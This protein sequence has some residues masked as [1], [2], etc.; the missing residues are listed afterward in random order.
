MY[1]T[2]KQF[3]REMHLHFDEYSTFLRGLTRRKIKGLNSK[4]RKLHK[5]AFKVIDCGACANCCKTMSPVYNRADVRRISKHVGM[6]KEAYSKKYL[7]KDEEGDIVH[8]RTPCHFLEKDNRCSIYEIR[9]SDCRRYPHTQ[10]KDFVF[11][12]E[13]HI[14]NI[15]ECPITFHVVKRLNEMVFS[16]E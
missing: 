5:E 15:A 7:I 14:N 8:K 10:R 3:K 4:V 6:T 2:L 12:R 13:V 11:Q 16:K 1:Q 9:P